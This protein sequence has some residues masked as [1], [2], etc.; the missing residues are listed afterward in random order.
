VTG[1]DIAPK[2]IKLARERALSDKETYLCG[3]VLETDLPGNIDVI[4]A[5]ESLY[6]FDDL[7]K[8]I[9][10]LAA[11]LTPGGRILFGCDFHKEN[12]QTAECM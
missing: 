9:Q 7:H 6:Y 8:G 1:I 12:P 10:R 5:M 4:F 2:M 3:D 11:C